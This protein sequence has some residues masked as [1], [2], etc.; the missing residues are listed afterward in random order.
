MV[1]IDCETQG[2]RIESSPVWDKITSPIAGYVSDWWISTPN[3]GVYSPGLGVCPGGVNPPPPPGPGPP[4]PILPP[5]GGGGIDAAMLRPPRSSIAT[6][7][8]DR[9]GKR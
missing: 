9:A 6:I 5:T 8:S 7:V 1:T 4:P 3:V 2:E